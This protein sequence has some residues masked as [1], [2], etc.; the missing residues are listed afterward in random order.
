MTALCPIHKT[1]PE[2]I[3]ERNW[4]F[5]LSKYQQPLLKFYEEHPRSSSRKFGE[6]R[7]CGS[8]K[9]AS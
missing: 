3:K 1:K 6:T 2:W 4:F 9:P 7:F 8:S 5:R